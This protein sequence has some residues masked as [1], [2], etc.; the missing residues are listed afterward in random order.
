MIPR[1][2]A[3][4][5]AVSFLEG[6]L[7]GMEVVRRAQILYGAYPATVGLDGEDQARAHGLAFEVHGASPADPMLAAD[8]GAGET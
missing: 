1:S 4:L 6:G 8:V 2:E 7:E 3:T 5:Q